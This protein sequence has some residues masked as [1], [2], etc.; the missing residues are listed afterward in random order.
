MGRGRGSSSTTTGGVKV[1]I[2][3]RTPIEA[4]FYKLKKELE[5]KSLAQILKENSIVADVI[6]NIDSQNI[7]FDNKI[8]EVD[9]Y[10]Y[11][12]C[13]SSGCEEEGI[14][15]CGTI[16]SV[17]IDLKK[18]ESY[19]KRMTHSIVEELETQNELQKTNME[20]FLSHIKSG[21]QLYEDGEPSEEDKYLAYLD[22]ENRSHKRTFGVD[23]R[24]W[25][26]KTRIFDPE[27]SRKIS[28]LTAAQKKEI[29]AIIMNQEL[30]SEDLEEIVDGDYYGESIEGIHF[31]DEWNARLSSSVE[32]YLNSLP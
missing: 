24:W 1:K 6:P 32:D 4:R 3:K 28:D 20:Y 17:S 12:S 2:R 11:Y 25:I 29:K 8:I 18:P 27:M 30:N 13:E 16:E 10:S 31:T 14:C 26:G 19:L 23:R 5:T 7:I 22:Y 9:S 21:K 15:R